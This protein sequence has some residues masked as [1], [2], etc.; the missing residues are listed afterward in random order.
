MELGTPDQ[1]RQ[2]VR[3][4][5]EETN[6]LNLGGVF[7]DTSSEINPM[8]KPENFVAMVETVGEIWNPDFRNNV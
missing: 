6:V 8:I 4:I 1:V 2:Q 5:I 7:I 3:R